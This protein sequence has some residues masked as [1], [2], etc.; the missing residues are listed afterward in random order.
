MDDRLHNPS[1]HDSLRDR[2]SC[3]LFSLRGWLN[4]SAL[5]VIVG[6]LV[7]LFAGYPIIDFY[8]RASLSTYG[9]YNV[10]G[11]NSTGQVPDI[12][13]LPSLI[14]ADTPESALTRTGFDGHQYVLA[15]SDEASPFPSFFALCF[16]PS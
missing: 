7:T 9:A 15:F 4:A 8:T 2:A 12:P 14:D 10:G 11:I 16:A 3:T 5:L 6:A 13:G 1:P